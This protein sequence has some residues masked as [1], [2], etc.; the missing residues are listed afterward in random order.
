MN[1]LKIC[2]YTICKNEE[3]FA[4]RWLKSAEEA[5]A[6]FVND[7]G[8][9]DK[10]IEILKSHPKVTLIE[11]KTRGENFRFDKAWNEVLD[12]IPDDFDFCVRLDMDMMLTCGWY[13][14]LKKLI[15]DMIDEKKFM[16]STQTLSFGV[17]Q[18]ERAF[19]DT[20]GTAGSRWT[21]I[22]H[23]YSKSGKYFGPVHEKH[24]FY[25]FKDHFGEMVPS[26][27]MN[28]IHTEKSDKVSK[29]KFYDKL[30]EKRFKEFPTY[31]NYLIIFG[32]CLPEKHKFYL[33][34]ID[35][36]L[37]EISEPTN[38]TLS[39]LE[40]GLK[41]NYEN[42]ATRV[43]ILYVNFLIKKFII[44]NEEKAKEIMEEIKHINIIVDTMCHKAYLNVCFEKILGEAFSLQNDTNIFNYKE[45]L[46]KKDGKDLYNYF[47]KTFDK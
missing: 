39:K 10:T 34:L 28:I 23:S 33:N 46:I 31:L 22:I 25:D 13:D 18:I 29:I 43:H 36:V 24:A 19:D 2:V 1:N 21:C 9:T 45:N 40:Q 6:I 8:S 4:E 5:D 44:K 42:L 14:G 3:Y 17:F 47:I 12:I 30:S 38:L 11:G 7:T 32:S 35:E 41:I 16:P 37:N 27:L 15:S 20:F 26:C